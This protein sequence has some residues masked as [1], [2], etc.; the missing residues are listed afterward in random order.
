MIKYKCPISDQ[1][2]EKTIKNLKSN[3]KGLLR[4]KKYLKNFL[5]KGVICPDLYINENIEFA[6]FPSPSEA[7]INNYYSLTI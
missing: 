7:F 6:F 5:R 1:V 4:I 3:P 2:C